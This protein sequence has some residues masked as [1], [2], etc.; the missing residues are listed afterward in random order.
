SSKISLSI[1]SISAAAASINGHLHMSPKKAATQLATLSR[2][3]A[4]CC[5]TL[6]LSIITPTT[7]TPIQLPLAQSGARGRERPFP[8]QQ[9]LSVER[10]FWQPSPKLMLGLEMQL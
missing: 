7:S 8:T 1:W 3:I 2:Q 5:L 9:Q 10:F 4:E 6:A